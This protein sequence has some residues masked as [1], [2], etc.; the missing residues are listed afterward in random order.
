MEET[1][2]ATAVVSRT[3]V[4]EYVWLAKASSEEVERI[5][6]LNSSHLF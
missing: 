4:L 2:I 6:S 1:D 5:R 3:K